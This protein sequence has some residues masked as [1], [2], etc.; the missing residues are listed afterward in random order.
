MN[1]DGKQMRPI[2]VDEQGLVK[3][4]DQRRL[5]HALEIL[6]L[7]TVDKVIH[8]IATM[9]V[10]GAPLIGVT[11]AY[12]VVVALRTTT[13]PESFL[14]EC[15]RIKRARPTAVNLAWAVERMLAAIDPN[16]DRENLL[17]HALQEASRIA[18]E[19]VDNCRRIGEHGAGLINVTMPDHC[20][21][22]SDLE[23]V[24][25]AAIVP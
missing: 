19:E 5:P 20:D 2:W 16:Q 9:V 6:T 17:E 23:Q 4:I 7:S 11:G 14:S 15:L 3:V 21:P 1:V 25:R 12:G 8:A 13:D 24:N 10:R 18:E 22:D